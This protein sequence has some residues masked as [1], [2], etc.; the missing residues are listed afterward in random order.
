[1]FNTLSRYFWKSPRTSSCLPRKVRSPS[2]RTTWNGATTSLWRPER[3][4]AARTGSLSLTCTV[5][6]W[7]PAAPPIASE[8]A[9][10]RASLQR[11]SRMVGG[12][13]ID[14]RGLEALQRR[15]RRG[16]GE[17]RR[18]GARFGRRH[19][20]RRLEAWGLRTAR[21]RRRRRRGRRR[22]RS[23]SAGVG[24]RRCRRYGGGRRAL[25]V[26]AGAEGLVEA[27][28]AVVVALHLG[29]AGSELQRLLVVVE[30]LVELAQ[31]LARHRQV[32][33]HLRGVPFQPLRLLEAEEG[34]A[35][36]AARG[37]RDTEAELGVGRR[38]RGMRGA[39]AGERQH[40]DQGE[41][42]EANPRRHRRS[43]L[44][45][46]RND[47]RGRSG[48][49]GESERSEYIHGTLSVLFGWFC[50]ADSVRRS[51]GANPFARNSVL[52][53]AGRD[54]LRQI[55]PAFRLMPRWRVSVAPRCRRSPM[56]Y[57]RSTR[58]RCRGRA[59]AGWRSRPRPG[60]RTPGP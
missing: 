54:F 50:W 30:R 16:L 17:E 1:R 57:W 36:Q 24:G 43:P 46:F 8:T 14:G 31:R 2:C 32:V 25:L 19:R 12:S 29:V 44:R 48:A 20:P 40:R 26:A 15:R 59:S 39:A 41:G 60:S 37:H 42:D 22:P 52:D 4:S 56:R 47:L 33:E 55:A 53:A 27:D 38:R 3:S 21:P 11:G 58:R 18:D 9:S 28:E 51:R 5:P 23:R 34:F 45:N 13:C 7:A 10:G 49:R 35:P 6:A